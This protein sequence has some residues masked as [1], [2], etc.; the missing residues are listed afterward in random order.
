MPMKRARLLSLPHGCVA[1]S[2]NVSTTYYFGITSAPMVTTTGIRRMYIPKQGIIRIAEI[3][4]DST[5]LAGSNESWTMQIRLNGT[6]NYTIAST[7]TAN[8]FRSWLNYNMN[9][10]VVPGDYVELRTAT[11][12]WATPPQGVTCSGCIVIEVP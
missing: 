1:T 5:L 4:S 6:T 12:N 11:P 8:E 2:P 7:A 10:P 3:W 9:I